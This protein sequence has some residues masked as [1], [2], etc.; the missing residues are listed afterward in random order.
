MVL[1]W[2]P[3]SVTRRR[4]LNTDARAHAHAR[5]RAHTHTHTHTHTQH[6]CW[7][8][9]PP[10]GAP[11]AHSP[12]APCTAP[13]TALR[14][15]R[16]SMR[17]RSAPLRAAHGDRTR[18]TARTPRRALPVHAGQASR[19][20]VRSTATC[21]HAGKGCAHITRSPGAPRADMPSHLARPAE[22]CARAS[23][24]PFGCAARARVPRTLPPLRAFHPRYA[25]FHLTEKGGRSPRGPEGRPC[26]P[27]A[28]AVIDGPAWE[29][30][31]CAGPRRGPDAAARATGGR[32]R[33]GAADCAS[34][35][36]WRAEPRRAAPAG[37]WGAPGLV[38]AAGNKCCCVEIC[39]PTL[40]GMSR[41]PLL[42]CLGLPV[43]PKCRDGGASRG[44]RAAAAAW[45]GAGKLAGP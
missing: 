40:C 18:C 14:A 2:G 22:V 13:C 21:H 39:V 33:A 8:P 28:R 26:R 6:N 42:L 1:I 37:W 30:V 35:P 34:G 12:C 32:T 38:L 27:P 43:A 4:T 5:A 19:D 25:P 24:G 20:T 9:V 16:R 41:L 31:V 36:R 44:R 7:P 29:R 11:C 3:R 15:R 17:S 10:S 45:A 23:S